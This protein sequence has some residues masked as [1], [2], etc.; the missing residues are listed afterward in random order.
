V[1]AISVFEAYSGFFWNHNLNM[2]KNTLWHEL[3]VA[4]HSRQY[5]LTSNAVGYSIGFR[6]LLFSY[7]RVFSAVRGL[8]CWLRQR[9]NE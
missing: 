9:P 3:V 1:C 5:S 7:C 2:I 6:S 4:E 8:I